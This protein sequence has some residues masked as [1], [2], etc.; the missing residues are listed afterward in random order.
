MNT[1]YGKSVNTMTFGELTLLSVD[2]QLSSFE[3]VGNIPTNVIEQS[4]MIREG[5]MYKCIN[6]GGD[7]SRERFES[8]FNGERQIQLE[9]TY[10]EFIEVTNYISLN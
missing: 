2:I 3:K 10:D 5:L 4:Y 8:D 6:D 9:G 7:Y 1:F